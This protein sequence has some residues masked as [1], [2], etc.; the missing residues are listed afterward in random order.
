MDLAGDLFAQLGPRSCRTDPTTKYGS[1][2]LRILE[3]STVVCALK[4][5]FAA[6]PLEGRKREGLCGSPRNAGGVR[7][8]EEL[9]R[10]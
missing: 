7:R 4:S 8:G 3:E 1:V 9:R 5:T 10:T 6:L 2:A